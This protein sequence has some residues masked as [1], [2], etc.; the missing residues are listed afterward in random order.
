MSAPLLEVRHLVTRFHTRAG[1]LQPLVG[2]GGRVSAAPA[3]NTIVITDFADNVRRLSGLVAGE[4][5]AFQAG[6]RVL[7]SQALTPADVYEQL[8]YAARAR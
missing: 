4:S 5:L 3:S 1:V 8:P 7:R 2:R 6:F